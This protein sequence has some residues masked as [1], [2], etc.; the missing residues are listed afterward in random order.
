MADGSI[1]GV[2]DGQIKVEIIV[3]GHLRENGD[4]SPLTSFEEN[5]VAQ[6]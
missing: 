1:L 3:Q 6:Q 2:P 5:P 4:K